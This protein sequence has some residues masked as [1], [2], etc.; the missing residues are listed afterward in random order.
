MPTS[1]VRPL[2]LR[3]SSALP[4]RLLSRKRS[5]T[6]KPFLYPAVSQIVSFAFGGGGGIRGRFLLGDCRLSTSFPTCSSTTQ[7]VHRV[8][9]CLTH[10]PG[11]SCS[12]TT[13]RALATS[14]HVTTRG[15]TTSCSPHNPRFHLN[16]Y[17]SGL[18]LSLTSSK[19]Q[20]RQSEKFSMTVSSN[21]NDTDG[22]PEVTTPS[23]SESHAS[24]PL[25]VNT[26][27]SRLHFRKWLTAL[28]VLGTR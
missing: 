16:V 1:T 27:P 14:P 22:V 13:P 20:N 18:F 7:G 11:P 10:H 26:S 2:C 25:P 24:S 6:V 21:Y 19:S 5:L 8:Y 12:A 9:H 23:A 4:R 15:C 3:V 28:F 17:A